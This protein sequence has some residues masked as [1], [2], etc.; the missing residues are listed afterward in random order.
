M[1]SS[2]ASGGSPGRSR[3]D[4]RERPDR[5][6]DHGAG[7]LD[8]L[9]IDAHGEHRRHDVGEEHGRIDA[10]A[11]D[12]LERYLRAEVGRSRQLEEPV[13]FAQG[14][15]LGKGAPRL[16]HEPDRSPLDRLVPAG[17]DEQRRFH[18]A[19]PSPQSTALLSPQGQTQCLTLCLAPGLAPRHGRNRLAQCPGLS[20]HAGARGRSIRRAPG[21]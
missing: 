20:S 6:G 12:R 18:A 1:A 13:A 4:L 3:L 2:V 14:A 5:A 15:V 7:A 9:H 19:K 10:V 16:P 11:L 21:R 17:A 8:E